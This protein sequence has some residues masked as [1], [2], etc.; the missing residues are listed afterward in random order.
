MEAIGPWQN[1]GLAGMVIGA[2]FLTL[3]ATGKSVLIKLLEMHRD[4]RKEWIAAFNAQ[5][6]QFDARQ[7]ESNEVIREL[8]AAVNDMNSRWRCTERACPFGPP[9]DGKA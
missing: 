1:F 5:A 3:W 2:L 7:Q 4:E 6:K 9:R 8:A